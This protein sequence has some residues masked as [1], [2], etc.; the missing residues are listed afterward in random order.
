MLDRIAP[1]EDSDISEALAK[2][3]QRRGI[4]LKLGVSVTGSKPTDQGVDVEIEK[5]GSKEVLSVERMF[6]AIGRAT[7][8]DLIGLDEVG[9]KTEKGYIVVDQ[10][11]RT[12]VE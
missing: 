7:R 8:T 10:N 4:K 9:V 5:D 1:A 2:L 12:S 11:F 6:V 3:L